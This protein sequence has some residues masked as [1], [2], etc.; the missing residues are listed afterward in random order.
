MSQ[1]A[2]CV[3]P[4]K[5]ATT[6]LYQCLKEHP[7]VCCSSTKETGF[8]GNKKN[9]QGITEYKSFFTDCADKK[10]WFEA[11]PHYASYEGT[12]KLI[13]KYDS[14]AKLIFIVR[15]P[16]ERAFS[17]YTHYL[18]K[19]NLKRDS[20]SLQELIERD[21]RVIERGL[22]GKNLDGFLN[23]FS[24][25][26][27]MFINYRD[28]KDN[29]KKVIN[30]VCEFLEVSY[31]EPSLLTT[32]YHTSKARANPLYFF[33][34]RV[35]LRISRNAFG[36]KIIKLLKKNGIKSTFFEKV[37]SLLSKKPESVT[38]S[39][40]RLLRKYSDADIERFLSSI[41]GHVSSTKRH[42]LSYELRGP[43]Q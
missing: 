35:H 33:M 14:G 21:N 7:E 13:H 30:E 40:I 36:R 39:E 4:P 16:I 28:I 42:E 20:L 19:N 3:G 24:P 1:L 23:F 12:A 27:I 9:C 29:P 26:Q 22:Y 8:F 5:T 38:K 6:W 10:I 32:K 18:R 37:M 25:T 2:I 31:F 17:Q 41:E 15:N 34:T 43:T 11:T